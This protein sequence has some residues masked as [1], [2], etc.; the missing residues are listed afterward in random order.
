M[1]PCVLVLGIYPS[2]DSRRVEEGP[3]RLPTL[4]LC[5]HRCAAYAAASTPYPGEGPHVR[6]TGPR[7]TRPPTRPHPSV[8]PSLSFFRSR[9][10]PPAVLLPR[11]N[12]RAHRAI[13][14]PSSNSRF[15]AS[16]AHHDRQ[17][18]CILEGGLQ[19]KTF[20]N[21][22][23][24]T[25]LWFFSVPRDRISPSPPRPRVPPKKPAPTISATAHATAINE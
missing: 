20:C 19:K 17:D 22:P 4:T 16:A 12:S 6:P 5:A 24:W 21:L 25:T 1:E 2:T 15:S 3:S 7:P 18:C 23:K 10:S 8:A 14:T 9:R 11:Y 13:T